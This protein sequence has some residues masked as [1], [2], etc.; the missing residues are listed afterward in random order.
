MIL[1][2]VIGLAAIAG[3]AVFFSPGTSNPCDDWRFSAQSAV[4]K[5]HH[6]VVLSKLAPYFATPD[7]GGN[8]DVEALNW[9]FEARINVPQSDFSHISGA[10]NL[11]RLLSDLGDDRAKIRMARL[12]LRDGY[13]DKAIDLLKE[14][15]DPEA[16]DLSAIIK[17]DYSN[18]ADNRTV[19]FQKA[20]SRQFIQPGD[21]SAGSPLDRVAA[22]LIR[23]RRNETLKEDLVLVSGN[24]NLQEA[25]L[26]TSLLLRIGKLE[27][28]VLSL[29]RVQVE[30]NDLLLNRLSLTL[31]KLR[32]FEELTGPV[33]GGRPKSEWPER[34]LV[35]AALSGLI[36]R[37]AVHIDYNDH[38][39][40]K[41]IGME[42][43]AAWNSLFSA[44]S[45]PPLDGRETLDAL[46]LV[47]PFAPGFGPISRL[48]AD[49]LS[50]YGEDRLADRAAGFAAALGFEE[51]FG[52]AIKSPE[53]FHEL[54]R[55]L[56]NKAEVSDNEIAE[57]KALS[58]V[59]TQF[60][61]ILAART[62]LQSGGA[63]DVSDALFLLRDVLSADPNDGAAHAMIA[64]GYARFGDWSR[65]VQHINQ[66]VGQS[67]DDTPL[68]LR[69]ILGFYEGAQVPS[70]KLLVHAW[71]SVTRT[72]ANKRSVSDQPLLR[73]RLN[74][75]AAYAEK[76]GDQSLAKETYLRI[77]DY[78]PDNAIALNNLAMI[79]LSAG[80]LDLALDLAFKANALAGGVEAF[81]DTLKQVTTARQ[82]RLLQG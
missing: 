27:E 61:R 40:S 74:L 15:D 73:D 22:R 32:R 67:P 49:I 3:L 18:L 69:Q 77:L 14:S 31:F 56:Q 52:V 10:E 34:T 4:K 59:Q 63:D 20:V 37:T 53:K 7:C 23:G 8:R 1:R 6:A 29:R 72:E 28:T 55:Q 60:W 25:T 58:P 9:A 42:A 47:A 33:L 66:A 13:S 16:R 70:P 43:A 26:L 75:L 12:L 2:I 38:T 30:L 5:G 36:N 50:L 79:E 80:N 57:L 39:A 19:G 78:F 65:V 54:K 82:E 44:L 71:I 76:R 68:M 21:K 41:R 46:A 17:G 11:T 51:P 64:N 81:Q 62:K 48:E 45:S 24:L 35:L